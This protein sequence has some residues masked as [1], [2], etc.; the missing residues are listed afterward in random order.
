[1]KKSYL[2]LLLILMFTDVYKIV[3]FL[4]LMNDMLLINSQN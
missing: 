2:D 4:Q 1:M 3:C